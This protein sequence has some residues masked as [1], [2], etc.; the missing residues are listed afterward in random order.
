M[1]DT[2][3]AED[4]GKVLTSRGA[5]I[6]AVLLDQAVCAGVGNWI[7]DEVLYL[8]GIHPQVVA[9][10]LAEEQ[11]SRRSCAPVRNS[12]YRGQHWAGGYAVRGRC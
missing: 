5:P 10:E 9:R 7:A 1:L 12:A 3:T 2:C 4:L 11:V 6:K 8:A